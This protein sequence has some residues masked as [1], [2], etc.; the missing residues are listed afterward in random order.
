MAV[1]VGVVGRGYGSILSTLEADM[2]QKYLDLLQD[3]MQSFT[4]ADVAE[5]HLDETDEATF[6]TVTDF[7]QPLVARAGYKLSKG[8]RSMLKYG[9]IH[10]FDLS[11]LD[12][13]YQ[14]YLADQLVLNEATHR[15][16]KTEKENL[17]AA[18]SMLCRQLKDLKDK[19]APDNELVMT[20]DLSSPVTRA[21]LKQELYEKRTKTQ[22]KLH[23]VGLQLRMLDEQFR[24]LLNQVYAGQDYKYGRVWASGA[25]MPPLPEGYRQAV[26]ETE[27]LK[28]EFYKVGWAKITQAAELRMGL[29]PGNLL[30]LPQG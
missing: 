30:K 28:N 11:Y 22:A 20:I 14:F 4:S 6:K 24:D 13:G 25:E 5:A 16:L 10:Q 21:V 7:I 23:E 29:G 1:T 17:G 27:K 19:K 2:V 8:D 26:A 18:Y 12:Y 9:P 3:V 15:H